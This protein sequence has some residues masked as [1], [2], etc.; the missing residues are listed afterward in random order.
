MTQGYRSVWP[1]YKAEKGDT[2]GVPHDLGYAGN[3][4]GIEIQLERVSI[5]HAKR[6][7]NRDKKVIDRGGKPAYVKE[8]DV[9]FTQLTKLQ[10]GAKCQ[11][12]AGRVKSALV[13]LA[14]TRSKLA[15]LAKRGQNLAEC[16]S[17]IVGG[18]T[19]EF[20]AM[21]V[22]AMAAATRKEVALFRARWASLLG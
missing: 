20:K 18:N 5:A 9:L 7:E 17:K 13:D 14:R 3:Y 1:A 11:L 19:D 21:A 10:A 8:L 2:L 12:K 6:K 22:K 4:D 15:T 16:Q